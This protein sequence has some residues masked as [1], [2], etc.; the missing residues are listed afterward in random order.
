MFYISIASGYFPLLESW[1]HGIMLLLVF[2]PEIRFEIVDGAVEQERVTWVLVLA[3]PWLLMWPWAS[4]REIPYSKD[5]NVFG[6]QTD[7]RSNP[8]SISFWPCKLG[9][10]AQ[11]AAPHFLFYMVGVLS[12]SSVRHRLFEKIRCN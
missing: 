9:Q 12:S 5:K 1:V 4:S 2:P 7:P 3:L 11:I 6:S 10:G 8:A